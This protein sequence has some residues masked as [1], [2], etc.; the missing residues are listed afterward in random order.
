[1]L[2]CRGEIAEA[3]RLYDNGLELCSCGSVFHIYL[4]ALKCTAQLAA[5]DRV[6]VAA[7]ARELFSASPKSRADL[8][9]LVASPAT[10]RLND[11]LELQLSVYTPEFARTV[12]SFFYHTSA[13]HF[14]SAV[15]RANV[16]RGPSPIFNANSVR[17]LSQKRWRGR[18]RPADIN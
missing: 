17:S 4:P 16:M 15:H 9:I 5:D 14:L 8:G 7:T 11:D 2:M 10:P 1:M 13:R 3:I 18:S 6:G 12:L